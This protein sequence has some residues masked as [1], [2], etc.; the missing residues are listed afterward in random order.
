MKFVPSI[1]RRRGGVTIW[2]VLLIIPLFALV[3]FAVDLNYIWSVDG[4]LQNAADAA[5][6]AGAD[7]LLAPNTV[8]CLPNTSASQWD[9]L[10][11]AAAQDAV[12]A[13]K[14]RAASETAAGSSVILN[15][16]DVEVGYIRDPS[17]SPNT[18]AGAFQPYPSDNFPNSVRVTVHLDNTVPAGPLQLCFGPLLGKPSVTRLAKATASLRGQNVTGFSGQNCRLLP[19]AMGM[20]VHNV[21]E[22]KPTDPSGNIGFGLGALLSNLLQLILNLLFPPPPPPGVSFQDAYTVTLPIAGGAQPPGNVTAGSDGIIEANVTTTKTSPGNFYL[23]SLRDAAVTDDPTYVNWILHGPSAA[24][25]ATF[26][27]NGLKASAG[28][29]ATMYGGPNLDSNMDA[30]LKS[31]VGQTRLVPVYSSYQSSTGTYKVIGFTA[32]VVVAVNL[33]GTNP[34][35]IVQPT[36]TVDPSAVLGG[37]AAVGDAA[38]VYKTISLS[39]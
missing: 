33:S 24:D 23:V 25:L 2:I 26:G 31:V 8:A 32:V 38:F 4:Q 29:P 16:D 21:L 37:G 6:L 30:A 15:D 10:E 14:A 9:N 11:T 17:A 28:A 27:P 5:A 19:I 39:R 22:G 3:A 20:D 12:R 13:A 36:A 35:I 1:G 18:T 7:Q 34:Y